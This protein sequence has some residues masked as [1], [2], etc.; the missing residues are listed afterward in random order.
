VVTSAV[1]RSLSSFDIL[2]I[3][4]VF[5]LNFNLYLILKQGLLLPTF[6]VR[7]DMWVPFVRLVF[8]RLG[9]EKSK[10]LLY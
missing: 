8:F 3:D 5:Q 4:Q 1:D 7:P 9:I 6:F 2:Q 10:L